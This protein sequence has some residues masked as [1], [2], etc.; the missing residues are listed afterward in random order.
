MKRFFPFLA[1]LTV[2]LG[3]TAGCAHQRYPPAPAPHGDLLASAATMS[4]IRTILWIGKSFEIVAPSGKP[5]VLTTLIL[6]QGENGVILFL[7]MKAIPQIKDSIGLFTLDGS[8]KIGNAGARLIERHV[9]DPYGGESV[10]LASRATRRTGLQILQL[11]PTEPPVG[12]TVW[13]VG[14]AMYTYKALPG[15]VLTKDGDGNDRYYD[16]GPTPDLCPC[17]VVRTDTRGLVLRAY[18]GIEIG[19]GMFGGPVVDRQGRVVGML[20]DWEIAKGQLDPLAYPASAIRADLS[21]FH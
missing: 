9:S 3:L 11:A 6:S 10:F 17:H 4:R 7:P 1:S 19:P 2:V 14:K 5:V 8:R 18:P 20:S 12:S 16:P 21:S 15:L 13:L